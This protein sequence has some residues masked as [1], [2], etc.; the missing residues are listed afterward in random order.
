MYY[1]ARE[2]KYVKYDKVFPPPIGSTDDFFLDAYT[3]LGS[4][5]GYF[6]QIW[7][8]RSRSEL[9]GYKRR[10]TYSKKHDKKSKIMFGFDIIKGFPVKFDPWELILGPLM[11][12]E[13]L[14]KFMKEL[15]DDIYKEKEEFDKYT[16]P[17]KD[18]VEKGEE[19]FLKTHLFVEHDQIV[20]PSLNLKSAKV[21]FCKNEKDYKKL[22]Q[23]GFIKDRIQIRK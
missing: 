7:L 14:N 12:K 19:Y 21:I 17:V 15:Y 23:M 20:V 11:S 10:N 9:T 13:P 22:A 2:L 8:S 5:C 4:Y 1:H 18:Y 6:P 3:W 16:L